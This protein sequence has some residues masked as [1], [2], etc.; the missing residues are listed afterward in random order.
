PSWAG[1]DWP[2]YQAL[3]REGDDAY[4]AGRLRDAVDAYGAALELGGAL[5][6]RSEAISARAL[7]AGHAALAAGNAELALEQFDLVLGIDPDHA[8]ALAGRARAERLPQVLEHVRQAAELAESGQLQAAAAAYRAALDLDANWPAARRGLE[9]VERRIANARYESLM[10]RGMQALADERYDDAAAA[11]RDALA[12]RPDSS[13]ARDG[14]LQ[15]EQG[16]KLDQIALAEARGLAFERRERWSDA[17]AQYEQILETDGTLAFAREG[18]GRARTRADLD[19]KLANLIDNPNLLFRDDVLADARTLIDEAR[20]VLQ[21]ATDEIG[22]QPRLE[23]QVARLE[24]LVTIASTPV[25]VRLVSDGLTEVTIY[26]VGRRG[27]FKTHEL[28]LRTGNY[29]AVGS[30]D[31]YRDVRRTFTVV[32]GREPEPFSVIGVERI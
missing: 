7:D 20:D 10:S 6:A 32:P 31:G 29:T 13:E 23:G 12:M 24:E 9:D 3:S 11:F 25:P 28:E 26:R 30:R 8:E 15:A 2:R 19:V 22:A 14:I 18:L 21:R 5:I 27:V 1:E 4:L 17:I 16:A